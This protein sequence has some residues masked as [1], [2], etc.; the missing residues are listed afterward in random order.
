MAAKVVPAV[1]TASGDERLPV[2]LD[3]SSCVEGLRE[4][5]A[6]RAPDVPVLDAVEF[7][8]QHVLPHVQVKPS[9]EPLVVH[10][11]CSGERGGT[12]AALLQIAEALSREVVVP[13]GWGCC[14][15]AGDRGLLH[16][17]L[18]A[19]ATRR[20]AEQVRAST[21]TAY[22]SHNRTCEIGMTKATGR[23]YRHVLQLLARAVASG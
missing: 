3:A 7:V 12:T 11:T 6:E 16:P 4:M 20:E 19:A 2:V 23:P 18:T 8:A 14:A 15:F 5:L 1:R 17:E 22:A 10:P 9:D 21:A 13:T